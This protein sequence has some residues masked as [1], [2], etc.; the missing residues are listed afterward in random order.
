MRLKFGHLLVYLCI[1]VLLS[2]KANAHANYMVFQNGNEEIP[3]LENPISVSYIKKNLVKDSPRLILTP[4][5]EKILKEKL[6]NNPQVQSYYRYLKDEATQILEK[7]LLTRKLKGFRLLS[8]S[9]EMARRMGVLSMIYRIDGNS[10]ILERIDAELKA[11]C[12]FKDWNPRHF[13]DVAEMAFAVSIGIDWVGEKLP[14]ETVKLAKTA[15]IEKGIRPS[16]NKDYNRWWINSSNNWNQ[17]C[18]GGLIAASLAIAD[19]NTELAAKT[20]S[21]ALNNL[22]NSLKEYVPDGVY[23]EGPSYWE[24]GTSYMALSSSML[25][26]AVGEDFGISDYPGF[27]KSADFRLLATAPSG[28]F[29]NFADSDGKKG[30]SGSVLLAW[31]ASQT[32]DGIYFDES[33]FDNPANAGRLAGPGMVWLSQFD[34]R[35]TSELPLEWY[36]DGANPVVFFRGEEDDPGQYYLAAKGGSASI[37]HG[38]MDA[39]SFVFELNGVRWV[40][41]PGNQAYYPLNKIDFR[42]FDACQDCP[43]WTLLTKKNQGHSTITVDNKRHNADGYAPITKFNTG[44][45]PEAT[46]DLTEIFSGHGNLKNIQRKFIKENSRSLLIKDQFVTEYPAKNITWAIMTTAN[47]E[48]KKFGAILKQDG[49]E[50]KLSILSPEGVQASVISLD[51]PPMKI[52]KEIENLKRLE[53]RVPTWIFEGNEGEIVVRLSG[54]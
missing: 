44:E 21:R 3:K 51:P 45:N 34:E 39:G 31:F 30:G 17:V 53:I 20:I 32:N 50:L 26:T 28:Y 52:D 4:S 18:H 54:N 7:P 40:V 42:L 33:F 22:P 1:L 48:L 10:E 5:K 29:F 43:R 2:M 15:L 14:Q 35:K 37:S 19:L 49:E 8:V 36:G 38:N 24:Y 6:K 25:T 16:F 12:N 41:D 27:M 13:L 11:V 23:P 47:V 9:R 46:V